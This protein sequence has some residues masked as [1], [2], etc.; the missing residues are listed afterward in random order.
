MDL[1]DREARLDAEKQANWFDLRLS[2]LSRLPEPR[3]QDLRAL[4]EKE[5]KNAYYAFADQKLGARIEKAATL[6]DRLD[7]QQRS[8]LWEGLF[9]GLAPHLERAWATA[10]ERPISTDYECAPFRAPH[11]QSIARELRAKF[12]LSICDGLRGFDPRPGWLAA[13]APHL[14]GTFYDL[15]AKSWLLASVLRG[16]GPDADEVRSVIVDSINGTH[17]IGEMGHHAIAALLNSDDRADWEVIGKLLLAA[18]RQEG[19]RQSILETADEA[20]PAA[21]RYLLGLV[22]EH[23]LGRFSAVVRA[24]D[25][26]L[27]YQWAGGSAK[28]VHDGIRKLCTFMD[29]EDARGKAIASGEAE[30]AYL[31]LWAEAHG[32]ADAALKSAAI[33]ANDDDPGRR[34]AGLIIAARTGLVPEAI[35]IPAQRIMGGEERDDRILTVICVL[36]GRMDYKA[37]GYEVSDELFDAVAREFERCPAKKKPLDNLIWP[38]DGIVRERRDAARALSAFAQSNPKK[39]LPFADALDGFECAGIIQEMAGIGSRWEY[40]SSGKTKRKRRTLDTDERAFVVRMMVDTRQDVHFAAFRALEGSAVTPEEV[41]LLSSNLHRTSATFRR[42][43]IDRLLALPPSERLAVGELLLDAKQA[44]KRVAGLELLESIARDADIGREVVRRVTERKESFAGDPELE[45]ASKR[46]LGETGSVVRLDECLGLVAPG[47][48]AAPIEPVHKKVKRETAAAKACLKSLAELFL[49]HGE[50]EIELGADEFEPGMAGTK[51]QITSSFPRPDRDSIAQG[52]PSSKL[53]DR[54][55]LREVWCRW[56]E[57]RGPALRDDDGLELIRAWA[58]VHDERNVWKKHVPRAF[59]AE[60]GW[61]LRSAFEDLVEWLPILDGN[62]NALAYLVQS[63]EDWIAEIKA[64]SGMGGGYSRRRPHPLVY[65]LDAIESL[66]SLIPICD[67]NVGVMARLGA[68]KMV[69][70][71]LEYCVEGPSIDEFGMAYNAGLVN[72]NDFVWLLLKPR[73]WD[74]AWGEDGAGR[75]PGAG[76]IREATGLDLTKTFAGRPELARAAALVRDRLVEIELTRGECATPATRGAGEI[77]CAGG[78]DVLFRL[79]SALGNDPI[80]RHEQWGEPTRAFSFSRL[81]SVTLPQSGDT[82]E[83]FGELLARH[84]VKP[85]RMLEVGMYAP[86]WAGHIERAIGARGFEDAVWWIH[87]HTKRSDTWRNQ[88]IREIWTAQIKERTELDAEDLEEGAVDVSWFNR[89]I[90]TIGEEAWA[91]YQKPARYA[92]NSGGHKRAQLFADAMLNRVSSEDLATRI[93]GKRN[94]DAVRALGLVP[95]PKEPTTAAAETL[96]RY[97]RFQEF[98]RES[99]Q[100]GSQRQASEGRA[101]DIGMQNLARTAGFRDPRR[102]QWA[103]EAEAVADLAQGPVTVSVGPTSVSLA[104]DAGGMPEFTVI[105]NGKTLQSVPAALRRD[106]QIAELKSRVT[107]LRRQG[108]RMRSSL[109]ESM[110]RGDEFSAEEIAGFFAHPMLRPM[111][112]RLVF[113]GCGD[114]ASALVGYPDKDGRVLRS[115]SGAPEPVGR[116]DTLRLAHPSDLF[117]HGDWHLWQRECFEAERVQPFKQVFRELYP[118]TE[119][120]RG[121]TDMSRRYAGHQVNPRQA[122]ALLKKRQW[123][124]ASEE[125]CRRVYHDEGLVAELWFQ[126]HFYTPADVDGLMLEGVAFRKKGSSGE[127]VPLAGVPERIFSETM[128][129]L[130][131]VVSVAHAGGVDPEASASTIEMRATLVRET[132]SLLGLGNVRVEGQHVMVDGAR[133]SYSVHLGSATT[134]VLPGRILVIVAVHSQY[135]GRLFLPFADDDPRTAEVMAKTLLLARDTEIKDPS[136]LDQIRDRVR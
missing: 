129:D 2:T 45:A 120:E 46:I 78:A 76:P 58:I 9:P 14:P 6:F 56:A 44:K 82:D 34:Y 91:S 83:V 79:I 1:S 64:A 7:D 74:R 68:L 23:D 47:S 32:D 113:I 123:V 93:D 112:E 124:F 108:S 118:R 117:G 98:K 21:F 125:G 72:V 17:E 116:K 22:L 135:R 57:E 75:Q 131:L 52:V 48:R 122:L 13:W 39:I 94:L 42:G 8:R 80:T 29:D 15:N 49:E 12:F 121:A 25:V 127:R 41:Q 101:V 62:E 55:P 96:R 28:A 87:A 88:E 10:N 92:S 81:I 126:E 100:F 115:H 111:V 19:L 70:M 84:K 102:L 4:I 36:L 95:L 71:D 110:C 18:Q 35:D 61:E 132:C 40:G 53:L 109:E 5:Y 26:W 3:Q 27:G 130:D 85:A 16:G 90:A 106:E 50:T 59:S 105:K 30:D 136:I 69:S 73:H 38:W 54:M 31:A 66:T 63:A 114:A 86:Q 97:Q 103:M 51:A 67:A 60:M 89:L 20:N 133:A 43:A 107:E 119:S 33:L 104:I 37:A 128:R 24:F 134:R 99:R 11:R 77:R 65:N